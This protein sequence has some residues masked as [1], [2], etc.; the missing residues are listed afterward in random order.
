MKIHAVVTDTDILIVGAGPVGLFLA[1]ECVRRGLRCRL[2]EQRPSQS[3]HSRALA[4][5]PRTMEILDM[6]GLVA[7]FL[8]AANRVTSV[9]VHAH[10]RVLAHIR[11]EP[12]E[13]PYP[14]VAM[15]P[16][17]VTEQLLVEALR[18]RGGAVEYNSTLVGLEPQTDAVRVRV[19]GGREA[20]EISAR[21]V[22]GCDGAHSA[23][24]HL[25][26]IPFAGGEYAELFLLADIE[27][28]DALP[29]D[30]M[31]LCPSESGAVAIFPMSAT[32]RRVVA[33][34]ARPEGAAPSLELVRRLLEAR[35]PGSLAARALHW[36][37]YFKVHHRHVKQLRVGRMFVA[38]D[39]AHI[40]SPFGGQ[41]MNTGMH[42]VWNL[43]WKLDLYVRG[44]GSEA[45]LDSYGAERVP[46]IE[47]VIGTTD[48][49]TR[50][51][52]TPGRFVQGMRNAVIP[53]MS[54]LGPLQRAFVERLSELAVAYDGSPIVEGSGKRW[55]DD[56][57]RGSN[58]PCRRFVLMLGDDNNPTV[59]RAARDLIGGFSDILELRAVSGSDA[60]LVRPDGY[61]ASATHHGGTTAALNSMR[62][63]LE[64][65]TQAA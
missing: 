44:H 51:M 5:F 12:Q 57:L 29:A 2:I 15:V 64:R 33:T 61:I 55:F 60:T 19:N 4:I 13:S 43:A 1:N 7:P 49:L 50:V 42:D 41:G 40:H 59:Q 22:V 56:S 23:V 48:W 52:A 46:V 21:F 38:G 18:H 34:V 20:R 63:L 8:A 65:Q 11:F 24:R 35:G 27:T 30:Q 26:N 37:S 9:A 45:L 36:S 16:Q 62:S 47:S 3:A 10:D 31:Q 58:A 17:N 53:V 32:R 6:G 54:S 39:A 28:N 14:F 25:L